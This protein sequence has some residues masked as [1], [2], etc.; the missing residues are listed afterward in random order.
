[1]FPSFKN[2]SNSV[3]DTSTTFSQQVESGWQTFNTA[4]KVILASKKSILSHLFLLPRL[5]I[6][7]FLN[8]CLNYFHLR[9]L[10]PCVQHLFI[11]FI[12]VLVSNT[13]SIYVRWCS[14]RLKVTRRMW[15]V[16]R[17]LLILP[18]FISVLVRFMSC[19]STLSSV[20]C[21]V[22]HCS[23]AHCIVCPLINVFWLPLWHLQ[24]F[25]IFKSK[26]SLNAT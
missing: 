2:L 10:R 5:K 12:F 14:C 11:L 24:T 18:E 4:I 13:S 16:Y 19:Y 7:I 26:S 20:L 22:D 8:I 6:L 25:L 9:I 15:L 1:M 21:F 17:E 23:F 3:S